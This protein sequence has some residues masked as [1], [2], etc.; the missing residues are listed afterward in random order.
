MSHLAPRIVLT[1][2]AALGLFLAGCQTSGAAGAGGGRPP[3][4]HLYETNNTIRVDLDG[5]LFTAYHFRE[6]SRPFLYPLLGSGGEHLTRRWP[7]ED[8]PGEEHDHPHHHSLWYSHGEVNGVDLWSETDKAGRTVHQYFVE[9]KS[10]AEA[11]VLTTRN[12]WRA[13]DG[14]LLGHDERTFRFHAPQG[15]DRVIDFSVTIFASQGELVL[16]DTKEG[17]FALRLAESMR[18]KQPKNQPGLGHMLSSRGV[19]DAAVWGTRA[20]WVDYWG[21]VDGKTVGVAILDHP[22]NPRHPTWWHARDYGLFAANP[23]GLHDF[24]KKPKGTGDL[25]IP[26]GTSVTFR[27]RVILHPGDAGAAKIAGRWDEYVREAKAAR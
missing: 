3:R 5:R 16:G 26:A 1:A 4:V 6:V 8:V 9:Q 12:E 21:P 2:V 13:K 11:G 7:Q 14:K 20:E 27:Y 18:I 24:E 22:S 25:K 17:T 15:P 10:G 23:F 19:K